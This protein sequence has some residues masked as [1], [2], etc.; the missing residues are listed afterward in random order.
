MG[1]GFVKDGHLQCQFTPRVQNER[2]AIEDLIVLTTNHVE[3]NEWQSGLDDPRDHMVEACVELA[4]IVRRTVGHQDHLCAALLECL[5]DILVPSILANRC[6]DA[7]HPQVVRTS[8]WAGFVKSNFVKDSLVGQMVL[9]YLSHQSTFFQYMI[10]VVELA[11]LNQRPTDPKRRSIGCLS[12]QLFNV[13]HRIPR[14]GRFHDKILCVVAGNEHLG[15]RNEIRACGSAFF[16]HFQ[17]LGLISS[18]VANSWVHLPKRDAETVR[19]ALSPV[20]EVS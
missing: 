1:D 14:E 20:Q 9:Q 19:H 8:N 15:Q 16:P 3:V 2:S 6:S 12:H 10:S 13:G 11:T 4:A 7:H 17:C 18:K 5:G